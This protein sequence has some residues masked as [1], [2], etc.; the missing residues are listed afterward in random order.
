M[1]GGTANGEV[2]EVWGLIVEDTRIG[3]GGHEQHSTA[4]G[5]GADKVSEHD[6]CRLDANLDIISAILA[7][8]DGV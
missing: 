2:E 7:R 4:E 3:E 5:E 8:I 1:K 6:S